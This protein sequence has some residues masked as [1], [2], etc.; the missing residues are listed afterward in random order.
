MSPQRVPSFQQP[1]SA[2]GAYPPDTV[3]FNY[4]KA[5]PPGTVPSHGPN[6]LHSV[7]HSSAPSQSFSHFPGA[8]CAA[9]PSAVHQAMYDGQRGTSQG[10]PPDG[11]EMQRFHSQEFSLPGAQPPQ[12][13]PGPPFPSPS[14][15]TPRPHT[16]GSN[17]ASF[18]Q[19]RIPLQRGTKG[20]ASHATHATHGAPAMGHV[21]SHPLLSQQQ[22][23]AGGPYGRED[24]DRSAQLRDD[25]STSSRG[26]L[27]AVAY[28]RSDS[29]PENGLPVP[30]P[31]SVSQ[32][33]T[34]PFGA[35][36]AAAP[37]PDGV[38]GVAFSFARA[39]GRVDD[40]SHS[41]SWPSASSADPQR[42]P[43]VSASRAP[44]PCSTLQ[45]AAQ[46]FVAQTAL[47]SLPARPLHS[48]PASSPSHRETDALPNKDPVHSGAAH[49]GAGRD[50]PADVAPALAHASRSTGP[51]PPRGRPVDDSPHAGAQ[52]RSEGRPGGAAEASP[53]LASDSQASAS[54]LGFGGSHSAP[55]SGRPAMGPRPEAPVQVAGASA[56]PSPAEGKRRMLS[57]PPLPAEVLSRLLSARRARLRRNPLLRYL[58]GSSVLRPLCGAKRARTGTGHGEGT[59]DGSSAAS[60]PFDSVIRGCRTPLDIDLYY[61]G[62]ERTGPYFGLSY[63]GSMHGAGSPG[64]ATGS[65]GAG[66]HGPGKSQGRGANLKGTGLGS[67]ESEASRDGCG[68]SSGARSG[69]G[70]GGE[71]SSSGQDRS[72][73]SAAATAAS[74]AAAAA[75]AAKDDSLQWC[76]QQIQQV[77]F[78]HPKAAAS[79]SKS[80]RYRPLFHQ[81]VLAEAALTGSAGAGLGPA[82]PPGPGATH[83]TPPGDGVAG[84]K[85]WREVDVVPPPQRLEELLVVLAA[86][87]KVHV[88]GC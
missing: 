5:T 40:L 3:A 74:A 78:Q 64:A 26:L 1:Q 53:S 55:S 36:S 21:Q 75:A 59:R 38:R 58:E 60:L 69:S 22:S 37:L 81:S 29:H 9:R 71:D 65:G 30:E 44:A 86:A 85:R 70:T 14:P 56:Q 77:L 47:Q 51:S 28:H 23:T 15:L 82:S 79:A 76:H 80:R 31:G 6:I 18:D 73:G 20:T 12:R 13:E 52:S 33:G 39:G 83:G 27:P 16:V 11:T 66:A 43:G 24:Q 4:G 19:G 49:S 57:G 48:P 54:A 63:P 72:K 7:S 8:A 34:T 87:V 2:A 45:N 50:S 46:G 62:A 61:G 10:S 41:A 42:H 25:V 32:P 67:G 84:W 68:G 17:H 35:G 88:A